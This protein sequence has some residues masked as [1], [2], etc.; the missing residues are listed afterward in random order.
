MATSPATL[1]SVRLDFSSCADS[2][3]LKRGPGHLV[4][5]PAGTG[6]ATAEE[7]APEWVYIRKINSDVQDLEAVEEYFCAHGI[8]NTSIEYNILIC[9]GHSRGFLALL[10]WL[11]VRHKKLLPALN[12]IINCSGRYHAPDVKQFY[13]DHYPTFMQAGGCLQKGSGP[14]RSFIP[15]WISSEEIENLSTQD[16]SGMFDVVLGTTEEKRIGIPTVLSIYGTADNVVPLRDSSYIQKS[17]ESRTKSKLVWIQNADHNFYGLP[18]HAGEQKANYNPT[19]IKV[20]LDWLTVN[21]TSK[22]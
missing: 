2:P 20:I 22:L 9:I 1:S 4:K 15:I 14:K 6:P 8:A 3:V 21:K 12:H 13:T 19:V 17:L 10:A 11:A 5:R 18:R 7:G 16:V